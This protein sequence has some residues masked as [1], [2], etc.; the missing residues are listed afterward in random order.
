MLRLAKTLF[1]L[2]VFSLPFM[3][4]ALLVG[5]LT[6][7]VTDFL[8]LGTT[9]ALAVA[10]MQG[11][12]KLRWDPLY[13]ALLAWF[14]AM[15]VSALAAA[16]PGRAW[17]K[18]ATQVY[19]L[20]LPL[21]AATLIESVDDFRSVFGAWLAG[22]AVT[23]AVGTA[24]VLLFA[25]GIESSWFDFALHEFG[26][27]PAG[28]YPRLDST[29]Y[30]PALLCN[31]LAVSLILLLVARRLG[32][33]G[34]APFGLLFA[35]IAVTAAFSLTPGLGGLFLAVGIWGFLLLRRPAPVRA[36][37]SLSIGI[38]AALAFLAAAAVTPYLHPT[39]PFLIDVPGLERPIAPSVRMMIWIDAAETFLRQPL[40]GAGIG[41]NAVDVVFASPSAGI[42][43]LTDA[44]NVYLSVAAQ[45]GILGLAAILWLI[46]HVVRRTL[47]LRIDG[48]GT[49]RVGLGL[50]WL[51]AFAWQ[52]L[53]GSFEDSRHLWLVLGLLIAADRLERKR[54][55]AAEQLRPS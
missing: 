42:H 53:T 29:F 40:F 22:S 12:A 13:A 51:A 52:G 16:D 21:L 30:F 50:A 15:F 24:T 46:A 18:L 47:P 3:K 26:S 32:W 38:V 5:G 4:P 54:A 55:P 48:L 45:C 44:H 2:L 23:A 6:A 35:A 33:I 49:L 34:G 39:A 9:A 43:H 11:K 41:A 28:N 14:A 1:L 20:S 19:L 10:V 8:F 36:F 31:Y 7:T 25:A 17:F 37:A 27:L